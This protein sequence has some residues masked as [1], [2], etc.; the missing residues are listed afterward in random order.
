MRMMSCGKWAPLK[1]IIRALPLLC[2]PGYRER[3]YLQSCRSKIRDRTLMLPGSITMHANR[4]YKATERIAVLPAHR[5]S[6]IAV[7]LM[8]AFEEAVHALSVP[9]ARV[10]VRASLPLNLRFYESLGYRAWA[11]RPYPTGTDVELTLS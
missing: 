3:S 8:A 4:I 9:E 2:S 6:G 11:S 1:L 5:G 10:G 7:A